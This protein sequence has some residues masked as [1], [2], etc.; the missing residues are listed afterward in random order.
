[1]GHFD[2]HLARLLFLGTPLVLDH[3]ISA[4]DTARDR[5]EHKPLKFAALSALDRAALTMADI[6]LVDT[7]E[8]RQLLPARIGRRSV[9]V[10]VGATVLVPP[11]VRADR[12][13][14]VNGRWTS[15]SR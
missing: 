13:R 12:W 11:Q 14:P 10:A 1:M 3:L 9:I 6:V 4:S 8:H 7:P 2:I 5:G 15:K